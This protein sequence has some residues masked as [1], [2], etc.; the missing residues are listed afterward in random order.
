MER[1]S[2]RMALITGRVQCL[3]IPAP[4]PPPSPSHSSTSFHHNLHVGFEYQKVTKEVLEDKYC[5]M[6]SQ[7]EPQLLLE[8]CKEN[9]DHAIQSHIVNDNN[10][11]QQSSGSS[12][13]LS[14]SVPTLHTIQKPRFF[15][16][17]RLNSSIIA[18]E[19]TRICCALIIAFLV[20]LSYVDYPLFGR[21]I[22]RSESVVASRPLYILLLSDVTILFARLYLENR[23]GGSLEE[24]MPQVQNDHGHNWAQAVKIMERGLV[25]Y[26]AIRGIFIDCSVY[27][28]VVICGLSFV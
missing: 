10:L 12:P 27:A 1:E 4:T 7:I 22:V 15:T 19:T 16:S 24:V 5:Y 8:K 17:R 20:V 21:N 3:N 11:I 23:G 2:D 28:V 9:L 18:S 13:S 26:Q 14:P 25:V 6:G